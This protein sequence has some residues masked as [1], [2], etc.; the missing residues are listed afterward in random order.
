MSGF[1]K[2]RRGHRRFPVE[3]VI[4]HSACRFRRLAR[5]DFAANVS[6]GGMC[7]EAWEPR[8]P[9]TEIAVIFPGVSM[10][11]VQGLVRWM[12]PAGRVF[13]MGVEF[14]GLTPERLACIEMVCGWEGPVLRC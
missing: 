8:G 4:T 11:Q 5:V 6:L 9:G 12:L 10:V 14:C 3:T 13:R 2:E 1:L 7:I